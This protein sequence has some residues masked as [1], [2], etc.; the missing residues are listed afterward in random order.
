MQAC[1][2]SRC[3]PCLR[4]G[5]LMPI[6]MH[7][8]ATTLWSSTHQRARTRRFCTPSSLVR[9]PLCGCKAP[10]CSSWLPPDYAALQDA[11]N[12]TALQL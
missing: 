4:E 8:T 9:K 1:A 10:Y 6:T 12:M 2:P 5:P 7:W 3:S 11:R